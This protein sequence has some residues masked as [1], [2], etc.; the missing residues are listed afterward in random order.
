MSNDYAAVKKGSL[1]LKIKKTQNET[2]KRVFTLTSAQK[3][4]RAAKRSKKRHIPHRERMAHFNA[5]LA[6]LSERTY[7]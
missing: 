1:K 6:K 5:Q 7:V 2:I 4:F 3:A